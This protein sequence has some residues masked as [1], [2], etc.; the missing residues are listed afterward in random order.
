[1]RLTVD[2]RRSKQLQTTIP[3]FVVGSALA[4]LVNVHASRTSQ[5]QSEHF[6]CDV[7]IHAENTLE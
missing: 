4:I 1:M 5:S 7:V 3:N 2:A 6:V